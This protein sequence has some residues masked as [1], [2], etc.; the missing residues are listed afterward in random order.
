MRTASG[1][2]YKR[3]RYYD[4]QTGRFTQEDPIGLAGGINLYGFANGDPVTYSDPYGLSAEEHECP[5]CGGRYDASPQQLRRE[6]AM[7]R[8][9][10]A[11]TGRNGAVTR[12]SDRYL[13]GT[14]EDPRRPKA[15][16]LPAWRRVD[17]DMD[18]ITSGHVRGGSRVSENKDLFPDGMT[19]RQIEAAVRDAYRYGERVRTQGE[20]VLVRGESRGL[21]LEMWVNTETRKIE[22][23]YPQY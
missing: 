17:I 20:R 22:T 13:A 10:A 18:H 23:A 15:I 19:S 4:P 14:A 11:L 9:G 16:N 5:P 8:S 1:Q 2:L 7:A 21:R 6:V 3:N 12:G